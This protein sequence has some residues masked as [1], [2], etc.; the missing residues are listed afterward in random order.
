ML[1]FS[2]QNIS[3]NSLSVHRKILHDTDSRIAEQTFEASSNPWIGLKLPIGSRPYS[4]PIKEHNA[5]KSNYMVN[6]NRKRVI[7]TQIIFEFERWIFSGS[8]K[9]TTMIVIIKIWPK[10]L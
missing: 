5:M 7:H 2:V 9:V 6:K 3:N 8:P 10:K 1:Y 4:V